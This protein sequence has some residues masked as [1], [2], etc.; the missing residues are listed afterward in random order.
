MT[1]SSWRGH[2]E[3]VYISNFSGCVKDS[4]LI[5]PRFIILGKAFQSR[6]YWARG[7][8]SDHIAVLNAFTAWYSKMPADY[9]TDADFKRK[10]RRRGLRR[11]QS[12]EGIKS[13]KENG[14]FTTLVRKLYYIQCITILLNL[15]NFDMQKPCKKSD[16]PSVM[17]HHWC[18]VLL[19]AIDLL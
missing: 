15:Q 14:S 11:D 7:T 8:N 6:W 2:F 19:F 9:R 13:E 12:E 4:Q 18:V 10:A 5:N 16:E 1:D 3:I 17:G